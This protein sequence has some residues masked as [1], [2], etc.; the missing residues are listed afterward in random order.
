MFEDSES[1]KRAVRE[2][3]DAE[4]DGRRLFLREV[5]GSFSVVGLLL[6]VCVFVLGTSRERERRVMS[7]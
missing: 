3:N 5:C 1:A 7:S 2:L 6:C 4:L